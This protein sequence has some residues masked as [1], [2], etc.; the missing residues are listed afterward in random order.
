MIMRDVESE[1]KNSWHQLGL[2]ALVNICFLGGA[3]M[4]S[5]YV[6]DEA[7]NLLVIGGGCVTGS[8]SVM[9]YFWR[10][11]NYA[12]GSERSPLQRTIT[13]ILGISMTVVVVWL[14]LQ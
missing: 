8:A 7:L 13:T 3:F 4:V 5:V 1:F 2:L 10:T 6:S 12:T 11:G 14:L 9:T